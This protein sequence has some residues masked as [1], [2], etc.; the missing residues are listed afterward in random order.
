[1]GWAC[2]FIGLGRSLRPVRM[3]RCVEEDGDSVDH[4]TA[5]LRFPTLADTTA[6]QAGAAQ[7]TGVGPQAPRW[8][9]HSQTPPMTSDR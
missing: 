5:S 1:M 6:G 9:H 2:H 3:E 8:M 7:H 4:E